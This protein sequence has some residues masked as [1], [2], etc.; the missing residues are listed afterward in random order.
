MA[1]M[2]YPHSLSLLTVVTTTVGS[3]VDAERLAQ[4]SV[5]ARV[6][7]CAQVEAITSHYVWDGALEHS[8]EW[9][10][11]FKTLPSV[12]EHL[13]DWL[14]TVHPYEVPQLLQRTEHANAAY[15]AWVAAQVDASV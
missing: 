10:V 2:N 7:A 4:G 3:A 15:A 6:A 1:A 8:P 11:V 13:W 5:Q 12:V 14:K 9:R